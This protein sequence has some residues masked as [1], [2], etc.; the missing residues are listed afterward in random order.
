MAFD[1]QGMFGTIPKRQLAI[2]GGIVGLLLLAAYYLMVVQPQRDEIERLRAEHR[3][4]AAE[5]IEKRKI[6]EQ[7]PQL[8]REVQALDVQ[9]KEVLVQL[10]EEKE[11]PNLLTQISALGQQAGLE[12]T[13]FRP[14]GIAPRDFYAEVPINLRVEGSFHTLGTFFDRVSK[15]PRIVTVGDF[16]IAPQA[17]KG[18]DRTITADF[19][20]VTY[21]YS[22]TPAAPPGKAAPAPARK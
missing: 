12:F 20:V 11:I 7:L 5:V 2:L 9:L 17:K 19:G 8:E 22:G 14:G 21:T 10:P 13:A 16:R 3:R 1:L 6:A 18:S 15:M 4:L